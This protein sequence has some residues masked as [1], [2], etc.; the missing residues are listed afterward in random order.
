MRARTA[1]EQPIRIGAIGVGQ[2]GTRH[3]ATY[4]DIPE[5]QVVA[6]SDLRPGRIEAA[7]RN[8]P[9]AEGIAD[10]RELLKRDDIDAVDVCVHN[11]KHA[12][13]TIAALEAGKHVYC[14]KPMAGAYRDAAAMLAAARAS[15]RRLHI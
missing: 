9:D 5:A 15:G 14:E 13:I 8:L 2:I 10:F 6:V 11:N 4:R 3:L 7:L 1:M 12:P